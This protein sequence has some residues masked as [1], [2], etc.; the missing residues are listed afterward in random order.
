M[1]SALLLAAVG[2]LIG[3]AAQNTPKDPPGTTLALTDKPEATSLDEARELGYRVV[4]EDGQTLY[5]RDARDLGSR[6]RKQTICLT[7]AELL[8]AR[9][10]AQRNF[11]NMKKFRTPRH[12][13]EGG[14][15]GG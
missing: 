15:G 3:C 14:P 10:A 2:V 12:A 11:E 7:E 13:L 6:I 5:C 4:S 9:E 1:R 8:A